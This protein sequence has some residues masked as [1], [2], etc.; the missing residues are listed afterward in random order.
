M[1]ATSADIRY[2]RQNH[3]SIQSWMIGTFPS[4]CS[5]R[6]LMASRPSVMCRD[7]SDCAE[8]PNDIVGRS[9]L[10]LAPLMNGTNSR[11]VSK[12]SKLNEM[13]MRNSNG[14]AVIASSNIDFGT[15]RY[16]IRSC[17]FDQLWN[18]L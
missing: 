9:P 4:S 12:Y 18:P 2:A 17:I 11:F 10:K 1:P 8:K 6:N 14:P 13:E 16:Q 5:S 7:S 3:L 15:A